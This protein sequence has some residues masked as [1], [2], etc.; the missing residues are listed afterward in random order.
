MD[1]FVLPLIKRVYGKTPKPRNWSQGSYGFRICSKDIIK[2]KSKILQ[3]PLG[4]K[5]Y[6]KIP[7]LILNNKKL[8]KPFIRGLFDTDGSLTLWKTNGK[9]YPRIFFCNTSKILVK[10]VKCFLLKEGL[11][12]TEWKTEYKQKNWNTAYKLSI[13]GES[14]L[15]KWVNEIGFSNP[16]NI[17]KLSLFNL[18]TKFYK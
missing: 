14:M 5:K 15:K 8:M 7:E 1:N 10:Q 16:K 3:L 4:K 11:R 13:N 9:L 12:P 2:F 18:N 17:K 6:I